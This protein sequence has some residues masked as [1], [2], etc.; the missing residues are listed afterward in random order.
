MEQHH[1]LVSELE[2]ARAAVDRD[3]KRIGELERRLDET[4]VAEEEA[5]T[6]VSQLQAALAMREEESF[7]AQRATDAA[8]QQAF[9]LQ[10]QLDEAR[11]AL[12]RGV[13]ERL[14]ELE[15]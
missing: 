6:A 4:L 12:R 8:L 5:R 11:E 10:E 3:A 14:W 13:R 7:E 2:A 1:A 15:P 9:D